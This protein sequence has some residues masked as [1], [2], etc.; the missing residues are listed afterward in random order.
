MV[1]RKFQLAA[2]R[3]QA[4]LKA[5]EQ[6]STNHTVPTPVEHEPLESGKLWGKE[7]PKVVFDK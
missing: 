5:S 6:S 7:K 3:P 1:F 2:L 4:V